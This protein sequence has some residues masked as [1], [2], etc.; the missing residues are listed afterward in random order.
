MKI[1]KVSLNICL[2]H[3]ERARKKN[4]WEVFSSEL[5][6]FLFFLRSPSDKHSLSFL[7]YTVK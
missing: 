6:F 3:R 5:I 1:S 2:R 7:E 4:I